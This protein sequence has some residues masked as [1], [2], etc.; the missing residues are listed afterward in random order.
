MRDMSL[1]FIAENDK[2][3]VGE[4]SSHGTTNYELVSENED[5]T[6]TYKI[7]KPES[8]YS[9]SEKE[10]LQTVKILNHQF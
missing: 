4:I 1:V 3:K 2:L 7:T 9:N 10:L 8:T 5:K 6:K